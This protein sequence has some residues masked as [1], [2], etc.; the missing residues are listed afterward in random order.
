[1]K[2][3]TTKKNKKRDKEN[4]S[5]PFEP[6]SISLTVHQ[7]RTPLSSIRW[8]IELFLEGEMGKLNSRQEEYL[9]DVYNSVIRLSH[10]VSHL[11]SIGHIESGKLKTSI[12]EVDIDKICGEI[13]K[14][15]QP[16]VKQKL[17]KLKYQ[18]TKRVPLIKTDPDLLSEILKNLLSNSIK[19]T[20]DR[21]NIKLSVSLA[22][23]NLL[24][25]VKDNGIG[26]LKRQQDQVF[27]KFFRGDNVVRSNAERTGIGLYIAKNLVEILGG[28][29][30]FESKENDG[31]TF[32]FTIPLNSKRK[33]R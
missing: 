2:K 9:K 17:H 12:Q 11:L 13:I 16:L 14:E 21:G 24:F 33:R 28:T 31:T 7:L 10:L 19:Y 23:T 3:K 5:K 26:I 18:K 20:P 8:I 1:M 30:W 4:K 22:K 6:D 29:I 27:K 25:E 32:Y 15:F